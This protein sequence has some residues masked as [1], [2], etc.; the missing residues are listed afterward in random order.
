MTEFD[1]RTD[2]TAVVAALVIWTAQFMAKWAASVIFPD[3]AP[4]RII[5]LLLSLAG[6]AALAWLWRARRVRSLWTTAG[7]AIAIAALATLFDTLPA[8]FG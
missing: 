2:W 6:L 7:L 8:L 3:A 5:G 1:N 4:G